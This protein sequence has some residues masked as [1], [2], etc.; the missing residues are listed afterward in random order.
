[1]LDI[2]NY[3]EEE[4]EKLVN[5]GLYMTRRYRIDDNNG[6]DI[7][8]SALEH[9]YI[10]SLNPRYLRK[11]KNEYWIKTVYRNAIKSELRK[12]FHH[13]KWYPPI[14]KWLFEVKGDSEIEMIDFD[15][16]TEENKVKRQVIRF[17]EEYYTNKKIKEK[18]ILYFELFCEKKIDNKTWDKMQIDYPKINMK[19]VKSRVYNDILDKFLFFRG[20]K[21]R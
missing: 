1:M 19:V 9:T 5:S 15:F 8:H 10:Q 12:Y 18:Y 14:D 4:Y 7:I 20:Y 11:K 6:L 3:L 21:K 17:I 16:N 13:N 2:K